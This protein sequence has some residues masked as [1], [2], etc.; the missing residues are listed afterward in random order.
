TAD[1]LSMIKKLDLFPE[2]V[3]TAGESFAPHLLAEYALDVARTFHAYYDRNRVLGEADAVVRA[4]LALL[5]G[6]RIV[7]SES[8]RILGMTAP[9]EM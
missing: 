7:L 2:I 5:A 4:R 6:A 3:R 1:D 8:L 9:E